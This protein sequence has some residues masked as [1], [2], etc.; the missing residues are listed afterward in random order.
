MILFGEASLRSALRENV[1]HY[2]AERNHQGADNRLLQPVATG[3]STDEAIQCRER[4]GSIL[5]FYRRGAA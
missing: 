1:A 5:N 3:S 2:H 4:H